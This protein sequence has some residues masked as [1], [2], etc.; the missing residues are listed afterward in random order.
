MEGAPHFGALAETAAGLNQQMQAQL[1]WMAEV[2]SARWSALDRKFRRKLRELGLSSA[3]ADSLVEIT[4]GAA[5]KM[6]AAGRTLADFLEQVRYRGRRLAKLDLAPA[7]V[8]AALREFDRLLD[9]EGALRFGAREADLRWARNQ[10]HF[11]VVLTLN[12]AYYQVREAESRTFYELFRAQTESRSLDA[13]WERSLQI[14]SSYSGAA[15]AGIFVCRPDGTWVAAAGLPGWKGKSL[16]VPRTARKRLAQPQVLMARG[17]GAGGVLVPQWREKYVSVWS[18]PML[19]EGELKGVLQFAF[20]KPYEWLPRELALLQDAAA[21][22]W[23]A[24]EKARLLE[25]LAERERQ[26]RRLAEHMVEVEEAERR[27]I[28]RELHDEAGQSLLYTRLQLEMLEQQT[29]GADPA[30]HAK[31][32]ELRE[33]VEHSIL[34]IRRLIGALSP[35]VL[36]QMGLAAALR[37]LAARFRQMHPA[38]VRVQ[39]PRKLELPRK[40]EIIVYRLVQEALNNAAKYSRASH[41][42]LSVETAD[43]VLRLDIEDDGVGFDV[44]EALSRPECYGLSGLRERVALLGGV[45]EVESVKESGA[46]REAKQAARGVAGMRHGTRIRVVL[47]LPSRGQEVPGRREPGPSRKAPGGSRRARRTR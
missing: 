5:G 46:Q 24:A 6:L 43:G 40:V 14:L 20:P 35:A 21:R 29:A 41:V 18:V 1:V 15:E 12:D 2:L 7:Q 33:T 30:L 27:R 11:L 3:Q 17:R 45:L 13:L 38:E 39:I 36:E 9:E 31:L 42:N 32:H 37:Q 23:E 4:P 47:P 10:L 19:E 25:E 16:E 34:E 8:V 22:C 44:E 26:I 28:S